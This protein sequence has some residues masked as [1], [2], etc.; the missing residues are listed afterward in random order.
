[1]ICFWSMAGI[2]PLKRLD[3]CFATATVSLD[4]KINAHPLNQDIISIMKTVY[5][6]SFNE[7]EHFLFLGKGAKTPE[8]EDTSFLQP[9][10]IVSY[11]DETIG[12]FKAS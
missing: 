5:C 2:L 1:M 9:M 3:N 11:L 4:G 10:D 6:S 8:L 7:G 12:G